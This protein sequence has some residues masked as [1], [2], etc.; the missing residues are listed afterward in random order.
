MSEQA[1]S[2]QAMSEQAMTEQAMTEQA[3]TEQAMTEQGTGRSVENDASAEIEGNGLPVGDSTWVERLTSVRHEPDPHGN[4]PV[5]SDL[6]TMLTV[7][8]SVPDHGGLR[9][10]R[11]VVIEGEGKRRW[12]D[13]LEAGLVA[14]RGIDQP[15]AVVAK[16]RGKANAAPCSIAVVSATDHHASVAAWEQAASAACT[17]YALVL[18]ATGLGYGAV[19]KSAAVL[20]T[21]PVREFFNLQTN[22]TLLGW[23]NV[24]TPARLSRAKLTRSPEIYRQTVDERVTRIVD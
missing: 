8:A 4:A 12:A 5:A 23:V 17:G 16:M 18:A 9:P 7:A 2:E 20:D 1:M 10:W 22:E 19:W 3:M 11:F 6:E 15:A 21:E 13:A 14:L 24:G